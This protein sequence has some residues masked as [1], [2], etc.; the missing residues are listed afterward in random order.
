MVTRAEATAADETAAIR[1]DF[2]DTVGL[3]VGSRGS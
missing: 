1:T 3:L 2:M